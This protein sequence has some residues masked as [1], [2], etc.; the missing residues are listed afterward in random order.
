MKNLEALGMVLRAAHQFNP[1]DIDE[2]LFK[3]INETTKSVL[4]EFP[5]TSFQELYD[6]L[7]KSTLVSAKK[8]LKDDDEFDDTIRTLMGLA[9]N[10]A[11][12]DDDPISEVQH[13][14]LFFILKSIMTRE[15]LFKSFYT[16]CQAIKSAL[17]GEK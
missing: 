13:Q 8:I 14:I 3:S 10:I 7:K 12:E 6:N 9:N 5:E 17:D 11:D 1:G 2:K 4:R 15:M 16:S